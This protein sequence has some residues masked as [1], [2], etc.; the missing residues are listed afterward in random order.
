MATSPPILEVTLPRERPLDAPVLDPRRRGTLRSEASLVSSVLEWLFGSL[1]LVVGLAVLATIPVLNMLS[2]G[3]LLEVSGRVARTGSLREGFVGIRKAARLGRI[4]V[5]VIVLMIP[6]WF[7]SS[8]LTSARWIDPT[9][10]ASRGWAIALM[11][12]SILVLSQITTAC[13]R[14]GRIRHFLWPRPIHSL[15]LAL[16]PGA[17]GRARDAVWDFVVGLRL[18]YYFWLGLRG[19]VGAVAWLAVPVSMLAAASQLRPG[20]GGLLGVVGGAIMALVLMH[21]PFLQARFASDGRLRA[22]FQVRVI[23]KLFAR[24]PVAFLVALLLTLASALPLYL[25]KIEIVPREAAWLPSLLFV[26]SIFPARLLTG[27]AVGR[28]SRRRMPRSWFWR[29]PSRLA[30]L[31]VVLVYVVIVYFTQYLSW[32]GV[33]SLYEQ[34]AFL[35]PAPFLGM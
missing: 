7:A 19:F 15:R 11:V 31:P 10:R 12:L 1:T 16:A 24:A 9:S 25:L 32:Y 21:L 4:A 14:G 34:H 29:W 23:R 22:M 8:M 30:M 35:V 26:V 27:W 13:L 17:Y 20:I 5:G 2:L 33:W 28:A 18:P 3:Y 6:L